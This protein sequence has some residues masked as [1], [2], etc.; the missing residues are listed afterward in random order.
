[1]RVR[2]GTI[3]TTSPFE[4]PT[5]LGAQSSGTQLGAEAALPPEE[6]RAMHASVDVVHDTANPLGVAVML[7]GTVME[8]A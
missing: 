7:G 5:S 4:S 2:V 8:P 6:Y 3:A 1:M